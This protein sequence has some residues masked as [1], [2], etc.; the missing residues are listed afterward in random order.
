MKNTKIRN[1]VIIALVIVAIIITIV[2]VN[3]NKEA[4]TQKLSQIY[5]KLN[6]NPTYVFEMERNGDN[7]TIMAK[8][9]D[10]TIIDQYEENNHISTIIKA[11][12]AYLVFHD[13][14]EYYVYEPDNIEQKTLTDGLKEVIDKEFSTGT[15]KIRG[16]KY[17]YEE[18]SGS[19]MFMVTSELGENGE[20]IKTRFFFDKDNNLV[21]I[22][23][24]T[25]S[26][27]EL[28]K[29]NLQQEVDDSMFEIPSNYAEN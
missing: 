29:V 3:K 14:E 10:K 15:E 7:K 23:T 27:Q 28:L 24:M 2:L 6:T 16:T 20:D 13:R 11:D 5:N 19:T 21:Y 26:K 1:I 25:S 8:K 18:Y 9:G 12:N 22:K 4:N 17:F